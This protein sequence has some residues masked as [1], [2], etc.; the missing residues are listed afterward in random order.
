[1]RV[2]G[3]M[4]GPPPTASTQRSSSARRWGDAAVPAAAFHAEPFDRALQDRIH[5]LAAGRLPG[6]QCCA[7]SRRLDVLLAER[8]AAAAAAVAR[9]RRAVARPVDAIASHGQTVAHHPEL[10]ATL[11]I[12]R[13]V[14]DRGA[15]RAST[16]IGRLPPARSRGGRRGRAARAVLSTSPRFPIRRVARG[17][18][19]RRHRERHRPPAAA[20]SRT[21]GSPSTSVRPTALLDTVCEPVATAASAWDRDGARARRGRVDRPLLARLLGRRVS[22][23]GAPAQVDRRER[24]GLGEGEALRGR[25][26]CARAGRLTISSRRS[27]R[28]R[29]RRSRGRVA[30]VLGGRPRRSGPALCCGA[31]RAQI[32]R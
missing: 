1:M 16:T 21:P 6:S 15:H 10:R 7:S 25:V 8:F 32:R 31:R 9:R 19:P 29:R 11:Q 12:G 17:V 28:S 23:A 30:I 18:E 4:S 14:G 22:C 3:L 26:G 5:Q 13:P 20:R 24:Y 2:I 27:S